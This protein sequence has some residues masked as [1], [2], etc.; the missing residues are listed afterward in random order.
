M[1]PV[2]YTSR[3]FDSLRQA[4]VDRIPLLTDRWTDLNASDLG[5]TLLELFCGVGDML[6]FYLDKQANET[7]LPTVKQLRNA[8]NLCK[9]IG[10]Q[11]SNP[12]PA[13]TRL[14][15]SVDQPLAQDLVI[16]AWTVAKTSDSEDAVP[17]AIPA[18]VTLLAGSQAVDADAIQGRRFTETFTST[19]VVDQQLLLTKSPVAQSIPKNLHL[20]PQALASVDVLVNG[21]AWDQVATWYDSGVASEHFQ[22]ETDHEGKTRVVFGDGFFGKVPPSGASISVS[23]LVTLGAKGNV[24]LGVVTKREGILLQGGQPVNLRVTNTT[25]ATGGT[26]RESIATARKLAPASLRSVWKLVTAPD[27]ENAVAEH[28]PSLDSVKVL[29]CEECRNIP[30]LQ[31]VVLVKPTGGGPLASGLAS[32]LRAFIE[33]RKVRGTEVLLFDETTVPLEY[34]GPTP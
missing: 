19:G 8:I 13:L 16:Q 25:Q 1:G 20:W 29:T 22:V 21:A 4:L 12:V 18:P 27:Y 5:M 28:F 23:Y 24:R 3:D 17:F 30:Y 6:A 26:D 7:Y 11:F 33:A 15:F 2:N 31:V 32:Q 10:Y 34:L 14:R 9:L